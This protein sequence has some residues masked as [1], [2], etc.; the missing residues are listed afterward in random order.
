MHAFYTIAEF[1]FI[2]NIDG[3][4]VLVVHFVTV[5]GKILMISVPNIVYL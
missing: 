5:V 3:V 2:Q 1:I 4:T